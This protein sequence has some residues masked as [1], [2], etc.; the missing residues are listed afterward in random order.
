MP[1]VT[2]TCKK[3]YFPAEPPPGIRI[4]D[5]PKQERQMVELSMALPKLFCD[6][7]QELFLGEETTEGAVQVDFDK[8]H[9]FAVNAPAVW[10]LVGLTEVLPKEDR[11]SVR[12]HF[13]Q[14]LMDWFEQNGGEPDSWAMD[15]FF[16]PGHGFFTMNR[17]S[18]TQY[19]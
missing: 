15:I 10:V 13:I 8:F 14:L 12:G 2:L 3:G 1:L 19:W 9:F 5:L 4:G 6:H 7:K 17:G 16:G 18:T 11:M